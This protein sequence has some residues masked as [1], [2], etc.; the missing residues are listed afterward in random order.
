MG[1]VYFIL[2]CSGITQILC[3]GKIFD[4]IRPDHY[5]FHCPMCI[6]FWVGFFVWGLSCF[7]KLF[8][9]DYG[10]ITGFFLA[11]LGSGT[12]YMLNMLFSDSGLQLGISREE[13][14]NVTRND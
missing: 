12:S 2:V 5:F 8:I 13:A 10:F 9:F 14:Q 1:L 6:G 11:C 7:T 3:Y 4:S